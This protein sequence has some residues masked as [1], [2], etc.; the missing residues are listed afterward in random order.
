[1]GGALGVLFQSE[2]GV[3][4]VFG[5]GG[6]VSACMVGNSVQKFAYGNASQTNQTARKPRCFTHAGYTMKSKDLGATTMWGIHGGRTGDADD[7]FLRKGHVALGWD[8]MGDL[9]LLPANRDAF[10]ARLMELDPHRK[11]GYYPMATGQ[12]FRFVH[13]MAVGDVIVYPSKRDK[14]VYVG[15]I[16]GT[17]QHAGQKADSYPHRRS[18]KWLK[19]FA[20]TKF[21][22]GALYEIG[23]AMSFFQVKTYAEEFASAVFGQ[24]VAGTVEV[25]DT[26]S[27]VAEDIEQNTRDFIL[28]TLAQELKGHGLS[29][30]VAQLLATMGYRTRV[31]PPGPDGGV[32]I[33]A[34]K[35]E[36]GF[37]PPIIK[38][39]VKST[40]GSV[41]DP[42]VS[43][44]IGKLG[45]GEFG[46]VVTLGVFTT[47][48]KNTAANK[49]NLKLVDGE[50]LV[51][52]V[53]QHYEHFDAK[54]KGMM[55]LKRVYVPEPLE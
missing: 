12:L 42:I 11:Q 43:Q 34:H 55:P 14:R 50:E 3:V 44:L 24:E 38:V 48:A 37:V 4:L 7:I 26:V 21:T 22:Q 29:D 41:G 49:T 27:Y 5:G 18:V 53:L 33:V 9:S 47:Q 19:N 28:K 39:Q 17:Y 13:E 45:P 25:D 10:K 30:F 15:E 40:E 52:L 2:M 1:M 31:S 32:D 51:S 20:R 54:Y 23:S 36:L 35:D 6:R 46:M 8:A 16:T